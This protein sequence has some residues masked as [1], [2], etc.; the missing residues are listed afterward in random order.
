ML[1]WPYVYT[2]G[3]QLAF[4]WKGLSAGGVPSGLI[5]RTFPIGLKGFWARAMSAFSP[6]TAYSFLSGPNAITPPLWFVATLSGGSLR[7]SE[8]E[9]PMFP[10]ARIRTMRL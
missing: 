5:R 3:F 2:Y 8:Y 10:L 7:I 6:T 4:P 9:S 1:R